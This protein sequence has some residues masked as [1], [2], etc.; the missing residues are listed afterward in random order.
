MI[1]LGQPLF[2]VV[3][4]LNVAHSLLQG[5]ER[6]HE[7]RILS[8]KTQLPCSYPVP[9]AIPGPMSRMWHSVRGVLSSG[10][11][12]TYHVVSSGVG[13]HRYNLAG[14]RCNLLYL[15]VIYGTLHVC[16]LGYRIDART[17]SDLDCTAS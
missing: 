6:L 2:S 9:G 3:I 10:G 7:H 4:P 14:N 8:A 11:C 13:A 15:I 12:H 1:D 5:G 16:T 17:I